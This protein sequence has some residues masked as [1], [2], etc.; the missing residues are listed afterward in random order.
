M[1]GY[2]DDYGATWSIP[3][4]VHADSSSALRIAPTV[5]VSRTGDVA[6]AWIESRLHEHL[7]AD[8]LGAFLRQ[9]GSVD[10]W[11]VYAAVS[12]DGGA[13]F[14]PPTRLTPQ[15]SCSN[16]KGNGAA[17]RRFRHGG[18]YLGLA[19]DP[20]GALHPLWADSRTG[21]YQ[22]WTARITVK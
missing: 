4:R 14:S 12:R 15:R 19:W 22:L 10:C 13:S 5:A 3:R 16:A 9:E 1:I 6:V 21:T 11:D 17:G 2:S 8:S 7:G 20:D 18:D